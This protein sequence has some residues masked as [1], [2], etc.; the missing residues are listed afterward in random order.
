MRRDE[1]SRPVPHDE[2]E[3]GD[4]P[5]SPDG[6]VPGP[7]A[8]ADDSPE[9]AAPQ[10]PIPRQARPF[11]PIVVHRDRGLAHLVVATVR[12]VDLDELLPGSVL[13]SR[14]LLE[15]LLA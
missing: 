5:D 1:C 4:D 2:G 7:V 6:C 14:R 12:T 8:V 3:S 11:D 15:P 9:D 13:E 10:S